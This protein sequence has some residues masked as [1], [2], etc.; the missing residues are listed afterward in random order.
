VCGLSYPACKALEPYYTYIIICGPSGSTIFYHIISKRARLS[1]RKLL[2]FKK[3]VW[4]SLQLMSEKSLILRRIERDV[5]INA[6]R[7]ASAVLDLLVR[8]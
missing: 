5:M 7:S 3:R 4:L 6:H 1:E 8:L 2:N